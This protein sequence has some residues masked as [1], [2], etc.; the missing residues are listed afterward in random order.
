M[1]ATLQGTLAEGVLPRLLRDLYV[2]RKNGVLHFTRGD[3][4]RSVQFQRGHISHASTNVAEDHLGPL[5]VRQGLITQADYERCA[6]RMQESKQRMGPVVQELGL[7]SQEQVEAALAVHVRELLLK[8]FASKD[9]S[10]LFEEQPEEPLGETGVAQ[11]LS[12]GEMILEAVRQVQDVDVVRYGLGDLD[13]VLTLSADPLLRFQKVALAPVDGYLLSRVDGTLSAREVIALAPVGPEEAEKSLFGL[14]CIGMLEHAPGPPKVKR[15]Q[16]S[17][18]FFSLKA[19]GGKAGKPAAAA[20]PATTAPAPPPKVVPTAPIV[21]P[22]AAAAPPAQ[23]DSETARFRLS[24]L[25]ERF[26]KLKMESE[27]LPQPLATSAAAPAPSAAAAA[28]G[29]TKANTTAARR[30]EIQEMAEGLKTKNHFEVLGIPRASSETQVK[31]AYFRL[32]RRFHPDTQHDS[33]LADLSGQIEAVFIRVGQAYDVLRN[34]RS[35]AQY[36]ER[37]GPSRPTVSAGPSVAPRPAPV[38]PPVA[39]APQPT[40]QPPSQPAEDVVKAPE[41]TARA[42]EMAVRGAEK[43]LLQEKYW[44]VIQML[45]P[46]LPEAKGRMKVRGHLAIAKAY[47]KNPNW[48]KRAE[49]ELQ[50][51]VQAEPANLDAHMLLGD[52]YKGQ[53]LRARAASMYRKA[54]EINPEHEPA[55]AALAD[56]GGGPEQASPPPGGGSFLKK[57]FKK[58]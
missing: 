38:A 40:Q 25:A 44:E 15:A 9:G 16:V 53:G 54:L 8:V 7:M 45:E 34:P 42:V 49:E 5:L 19:L 32:A 51:V 50:K 30:A 56:V 3:V 1:T 41:D 11:R 52:I 27:Q 23:T 4:K 13:R 2:G 10:Y 31:E 58:G 26:K 21:Q 47:L 57:L 12:T 39:A 33:A 17:T 43:L 22:P 36:E 6:A 29:D 18:G 46:R 24:Q 35:R 14:L 37:L 28:A 55:G 48:V 20:P